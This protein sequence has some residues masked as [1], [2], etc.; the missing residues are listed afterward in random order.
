MNLGHGNVTCTLGDHY[1]GDWSDKLDEAKQNIDE[2]QILSDAGAYALGRKTDSLI[3]SSLRSATNKVGANASGMTISKFM[4]AV[5]A[6]GE[7]DVPVDESENMFFVVSW[8]D[9][10]ELQNTQEFSS[11]DYVPQSEM[12][13]QGSGL[14]MKNFSGVFVMPHSAVSPVNNTTENLMFHR[15]AIGHAIGVDVTA[16]MQWYA[17][18]AAHF[19]NHMMSQGSCLIDND[20]VQIVESDR[21]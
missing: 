3:L 2:R 11:A 19:I 4:S 13:F 18:R 16:D 8:E 7:R 14:F 5:T 9:W 1:A 6:L 15:N 20:G 10:A 12:P 21:S 17:D